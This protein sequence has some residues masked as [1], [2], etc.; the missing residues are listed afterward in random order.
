MQSSKGIR[1]LASK[2]GGEIIDNFNEVELKH[3][4]DTSES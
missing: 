1:S 2:T 3:K 4:A